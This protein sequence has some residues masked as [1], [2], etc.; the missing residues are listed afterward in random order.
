[1]LGL[2]EVYVALGNHKFLSPLKKILTGGFFN[3]WYMYMLCG[4]YLLAPVI[5]RIKEYLSLRQYHLV[6]VGMLLWACISQATS[7]YSIA[8][9]G[10]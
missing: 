6:T 3:L 4:L 5:I 9:S 8:Y 7:H 2:D 10:G 1:M